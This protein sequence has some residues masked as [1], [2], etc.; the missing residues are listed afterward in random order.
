L[1]IDSRL[2]GLPPNSTIKDYRPEKPARHEK[3]SGG[4]KM[5][6]SL[7]N[8]FNH[9]LIKKSCS[10]VQA[11][12]LNAFRSAG[13]D[14]GRPRSVLA[15]KLSCR[16]SAIRA[17]AQRLKAAQFRRGRENQKTKAG[18]FLKAGRT[19]AEASNRIR[20]LTSPLVFS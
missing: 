8:F 19:G 18:A 11:Y 13:E 2:C 3:A 4:T 12:D 9:T 5:R 20:A 7:I 10:P 17:P 15:A 1:I 16:A 6:Q 14:R